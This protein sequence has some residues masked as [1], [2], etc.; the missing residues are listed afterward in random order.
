MSRHVDNS[1]NFC[2][3]WLLVGALVA[4]PVV[5]AS[6]LLG[7]AFAIYIMAQAATAI[8]RGENGRR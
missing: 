6:G 4:M 8:R 3:G 1:F 5:G 2:A 7:T